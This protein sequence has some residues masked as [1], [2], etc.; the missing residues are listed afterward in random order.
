MSLANVRS[1]FDA[2]RKR[3]LSY[4]FSESEVCRFSKFFL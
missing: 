3:A 2:G 4:Y 1:V